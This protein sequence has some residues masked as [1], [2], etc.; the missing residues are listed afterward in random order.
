MNH[1]KAIF[2]FF[3]VGLIFFLIQTSAIA[4]PVSDEIRILI[5]VF[6]GPE[7]LG[8]NVT[9]FINLQVFKTLRKVPTPNPKKMDF[10]HGMVVSNE[11]QLPEQKHQAASE[12]AAKFDVLAQMVLWGKVW[13]YGE[14]LIVQAY[15]TIPQYK[16]YR[17]NSFE[18]WHRVVKRKCK[19]FDFKIDIPRRRLMFSPFYLDKK[20]I[21][22]YKSPYSIKIWE[23]PYLYSNEVGRLGNEFRA[24]KVEGEWV[25]LS[26]KGNEGW[27]RLPNYSRTPI[28]MIDFVGGVIRLF[29]GDWQGANKLFEKVIR[30]TNT[31]P[32]LRVDTLLL[33]ARTLYELGKDGSNKLGEAVSLSPYSATVVEYQLMQLI[34]LFVEK[35]ENEE[36]EQGLEVISQLVQILKS[37]SFLL[38]PEKPFV[39]ELYR[40]LRT[41][42]NDPEKPFVLELNRFLSTWEND[43]IL[44]LRKGKAESIHQKGGLGYTMS[45]NSILENAI[46]KALE[47]Q[48]PPIEVMI[49]AIDLKYN[50]YDVIKNIFGHGDEINLNQL[51]LCATE[52]GI[53]KQIIAKAA[54]DATSPTGTPIFPRDEIAQ[55]QCLNVGLG[56]TP[57]SDPPTFILIPPPR[58]PI[59]QIV[60][61]DGK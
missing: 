21:E 39:C 44:A 8:F 24:I 22:Q 57:D 17:E 28:E 9:T 43:F 52:N 58:R 41:W 47:Q 25:K 5:P 56:Y 61:G 16:D 37:K 4:T 31:P 60:P 53:S 48:A 12:F 6:N 45:E 49:I 55:A 59:S 33:Q 15:L 13:K 30:K 14:G 2:R 46:K 40:F 10:G 35:M 7:K 36:K 34:E 54:A 32:S 27:V 51:C 18:V 23:K 1:S 20:F 38:Q 11:I 50:P 19:V 42:E 26:S 3:S 29:R